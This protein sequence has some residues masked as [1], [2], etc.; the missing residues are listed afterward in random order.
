MAAE[1]SIVKTTRIPTASNVLLRFPIL[2]KLYIA[3]T[4]RTRRTKMT[5]VMIRP[6]SLS[7]RDAE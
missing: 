6:T 4:G 1:K 2:V 7:M 5:N 3:T